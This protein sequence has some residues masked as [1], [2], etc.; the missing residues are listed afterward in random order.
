MHF[1]PVFRIGGPIAIVEI[2][3]AVTSKNRI[4]IIDKTTDMVSLY[5]KLRNSKMVE[6]FPLF[7]NIKYIE[8]EECFYYSFNDRIRKS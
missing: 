7:N 4:L 5:I 6:A 2:F 3:T 1:N 8:E